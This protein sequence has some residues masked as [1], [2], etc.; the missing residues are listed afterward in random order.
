MTKGGQRPGAG[1]PTRPEPVY[2]VTMRLTEKQRVKYFDV[3]GVIW[4]RRVL[5]ELMAKKP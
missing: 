4:V 1:R 3:G 5:N 2:R